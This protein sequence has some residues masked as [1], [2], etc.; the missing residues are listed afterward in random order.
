MNDQR[1]ICWRKVSALFAQMRANP[2]SVLDDCGGGVFLLETEGASDLPVV[3]RHRW[4]ADAG[5]MRSEAIGI[6]EFYTNV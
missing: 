2:R 3:S 5:R 4:D 6:R 1:A